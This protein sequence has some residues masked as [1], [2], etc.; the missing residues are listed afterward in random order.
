MP[1][2]LVTG[3]TGLLGTHLVQRL[4][5]DGWEV[6][7]LVRDAARAGALSR[8]GITLATGDTLEPTG[9]ARAA[10]GCDVVFHAAAAIT[11]RGGWEAFNRP[12]V[13]GTRNVIAAAA[14]AKAR[15]VH[16]S[17]VAV[18][19]ASE[20]YAGSGAQTTE[21]A[22]FGEIPDASFYARSKRDSE[23]LVMEAHDAGRLW[24]AA[25]R[26][27]VIYGPHDRQFVPRLARL[28]RHGVAPL[29]GGGRTTL[30]VVH[31][32]N[33]ADGMVRVARS[34]AAGGRAYNLAS[35]HPVT[36]ADYF[37]LAGEGMEIR[38][39]TLAIPYLVAKAGLGVFQLLAPLIIGPRFN[40]VTAASLD[41]L[42]RDNPFSS[43]RA[44]RELGWD[45]PVR[46]EVGVPDAFRW[47]MRNH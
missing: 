14:G 28:L 20:R 47:W 35:D 46:H 12:N 25:V 36:V 13:D 34:D 39:R 4:H 24:A 44:R 41:F 31:A 11:P 45:P 5:R 10:R 7:A 16:V 9:L 27:S 37:R 43:D 8:A 23:R 38:L 21:D 18:Y 22:P 26:P 15:L 29:V 1:T 2:A 3:A 30:S 6:R 17:S 19:G 40:A 33:V 32:A 42:T